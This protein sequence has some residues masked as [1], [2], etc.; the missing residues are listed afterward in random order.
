MNKDH[1]SLHISIIGGGLAGFSAAIALRRNGHEV[2]IFEQSR[3]ANE[4]GAAIH[5]TPNA[6]GILKQIG[7][8]PRES[9]AVPLIE[10]CCTKGW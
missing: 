1:Q 8:D 9:G 6:T 3:F 4:I 5:M 2:E 10:V 7:V